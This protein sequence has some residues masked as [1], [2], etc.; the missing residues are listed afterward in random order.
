MAGVMQSESTR[1]GD[2]AV[3][4]FFQEYGDLYHAVLDWRLAYSVVKRLACPL[5]DRAVLDYGCGPGRFTRLLRDRGARVIGADTS[6]ETIDR[7]RKADTRGITYLLINS[8]DLAQVPIRSVDVA[9]ATF[10]LCC[11]QEQADLERICKSI[12]ERLR[13]GGS[14]VLAEPHP[15]AVSREFY[16]MRRMAAA[17]LAEGVPLE[18]QVLTGTELVVHEFWHSRQAHTAALRKAGFFIE[19][20]IEPTMSVYPDEP[21]WRDERTTPPFMILRA[22]K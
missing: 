19:H 14:F 10:V 3:E 4:R 16:S 22:R 13:S 18:V 17:K 7:A 20:V 12:Y 2:N 9:V 8:G 1:M 11:V 21:W 15:D 5:R 6:S